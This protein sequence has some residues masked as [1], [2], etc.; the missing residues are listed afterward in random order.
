MCIENRSLSESRLAADPSLQP[1]GLK[2]RCQ[3]LIKW[4]LIFT[5]T[6]LSKQKN[7]FFSVSQKKARCQ[8]CSL[9]QAEMSRG[10]QSHRSRTDNRIKFCFFLDNILILIQSRRFCMV[11]CK[12]RLE[13]F[14]PLDMIVRLVFYLKEYQFS[15]KLILSVHLIILDCIIYYLPLLLNMP[16]LF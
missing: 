11:T 7:S 3:M 15:E 13:I 6:P 9:A 5:S 4:I 14:R 12:Q 1:H 16:Q 2:Y 10:A 8:N